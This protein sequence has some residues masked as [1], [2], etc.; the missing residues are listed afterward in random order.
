MQFTL[1]AYPTRPKPILGSLLGFCLSFWVAFGNL[2]AAGRITGVVIDAASGDPMPG[3]T[4]QLV[5]T[6]F[7]AVTDRDGNYVLPVVPSGR[8]VI[9]ASYIGY[10][11]MTENIQ[12]SDGRSLR[13]DF[14]LTY[15]TLM[16]QEAVITAQAEGQMA[17]IN[18][19]LAS[20]TITN[21][22]SGDRIKELP[23]VNA[24]ESLGRLPGVSII[25]SGG[26]ANK[27]AIRGLSPKYNT[28]TV[29][30]V[31]VPATGGDDRSVDLSL[32]SSNM[33]DGIEVAKA[34]TPDKDADAIGGAVD[35]KLREA[36]DKPIV[37]VQLQGGYNQL[38]N[39][40]KNYKTS[41][42]ISK[43]FLSKKLGVILS[44]S[45][46]DYDRSADKFSADYKL[47]DRAGNGVFVPRVESLNLNEDQQRRGRL[48]GSMV[49]DYRIPHGKVLL[50][51]F[52]NRLSYDQTVRTNR[53]SLDSQ[54]HY[55]NL[56][57]SKG[58][59]DISTLSGS[60]AQKLG[61][62]EYD[63]GLSQT[64]SHRDSPESY[65]W[66]FR[67]TG[68]YNTNTL[69]RWGAPAKIPA[70][71]YNNLTGTG[72]SGLSVSAAASDET[73]LTIQANGKASFNVGSQVTGYVKGGGKYR[74]M[75]RRNEEEQ[76]GRGL[77]YGGDQQ[78][79]D[80]IAQA[81]P[82][83]GIAV[84]TQY[85]PLAVFQS[86]YT[87]S[88]FLNGE[89]PLG[90]TADPALLRKVTEVTRPYM[91]INAAPSLGRDYDGEE[92][93]R[94]AYLMTEWNWGPSFSV[95]PGVRFE[96]EKSTYNAHFIRETS[97]PSPPQAKDTT[98]V[99]TNTFFLPMVHLRI[100]PVE[101]INLRLAYTQSLTRPDFLQYAPITFV[102]L[103]GTWLSAGNP[104]LNPAKST[105]YDASLSFIRN[106]LGLLTI[107]AFAKD[108]KDLIWATKF[109]LLPNQTVLPDLKVPGI[110]GVPEVDTALNNKFPATYKGVEV[111]WQTN[112]W[113]LKSF[114]K[115]LVLSINYTRIFSE[116][117]YQQ[118]Q[119]ERR[120]SS[121]PPFFSYAQV[122]TFRVGRMPNQ[123][124]HIANISLG[125]DY[126][127]FSGR[128]SFLY[129][130][131]TMTWL[132]PNPANDRFTDDYMRWDVSLKQSIGKKMQFFANFNNLNN[133]ADRN[134][135][136]TLGTYP[137]YIEYYGF[138]MDFGL[139]YKF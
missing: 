39:Y 106:K 22:V 3:A 27:I 92:T 127:G 12:V 122:D 116:T 49:L 120:I 29:N 112:F 28:V 126:K 96:K 135:Q 91:F 64:A 26:E 78:V 129:Q 94:A 5:G 71:A 110:S 128:V 54:E 34:L 67:E 38:Q 115:G 89:Y 8:Y 76:L 35:L 118:F 63:L 50:N 25:R 4:V 30:G 31:R 100:K 6:S 82:E 52:Y 19:Q 86:G 2:Y 65:G 45:A 7:G 137:T 119:L 60:I 138:T 37:D 16:G 134:F 107:S 57:Q 95:M 102:N 66:E 79:R 15:E 1:I 130:S 111:D 85:L 32:V 125:Y 90:Y 11:R 62:F 121:R 58:I 117:K 73:Q 56:W 68:A 43:R 69:D 133:R 105:N 33:L 97:S 40:Y 80:I 23:D 109:Y 99:R 88:N 136:A 81:L 13:V 139:R 108:I 70:S 20:N 42:N 74:K 18:Q 48:G 113:Y 55:Y 44:F 24:A 10:K 103:W 9:A 17:A 123:P 83:L 47:I 132:A 72:F 46:D 14:S 61:R 93:F 53:M 21:I 77:Y 87:R 51:G 36:P 98:S 101:W 84:K 104:V 124:S 41:G 131:D 59:T 114:L 75:T